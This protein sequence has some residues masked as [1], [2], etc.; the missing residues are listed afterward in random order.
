MGKNIWRS[1]KLLKHRGF[2]RRP[3]PWL[4]VLAVLPLSGHAQ[5]SVASGAVKLDKELQVA[6]VPGDIVDEVEDSSRASGAGSREFVVAP[7][8]SRNPLLGWTLG[9][10]AMVLYK[11]SSAV[12]ADNTWMTGAMGFYTENDSKG[13]G[14][15]HKMSFGGDKWR[16]LGAV[17]EADL[18]YDY[19]GIGG[20]PDTSVPLNQTISAVVA[21]ALMRVY[22]NLYVGLRGNYSQSEISLNTSNIDLPPDITPPDPDVDFELATLAP[23]ATYDSRDNEFYPGAGGKVD[24]TIQIGR[25]S[26]GSDFDYEKHKLFANW[27]KSVSESNILATRVALQYVGGDAPFY[28]FPAFGSNADLRGYNT[29][30]YRDRF[31]FAAQTEL[32]YRFKPRFGVVAFAGI[33][34]V[35]PKFGRWGESLMSVGAGIRWVIAPKNNMSL[36]VDIAHGKDNT[37]FYV[38][39]GEAF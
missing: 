9:L 16:L 39:L 20:D 19:F 30:T 4:L 23:R 7:L 6:A 34:T 32:R 18:N 14:A 21:E 8:P 25:M 17:F 1:G 3:L 27:Y 2:Y 36:R 35:A 38:G 26:L 31:L 37:E 13:F 28:T 15:F 12:E 22:P 24:L 33:G 11:P 10:P 29:G 5:T